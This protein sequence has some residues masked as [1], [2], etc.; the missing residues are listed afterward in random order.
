MC[1]HLCLPLAR[2]ALSAC[3]AE[4]TYNK[5]HVSSKSSAVGLGACSGICRVTCQSLQLRFKAKHSLGFTHSTSVENRPSY[6]LPGIGVVFFESTRLIRLMARLSSSVA[7]STGAESSVCSSDSAKGCSNNLTRR[8]LQSLLLCQLII[9]YPF[10]S[11][12]VFVNRFTLICTTSKPRVVIHHAIF[13]KP[14][15]LTSCG[16]KAENLA[17]HFPALTAVD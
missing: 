2:I 14:A 10:C 5:S 12:C 9:H 15:S 17:L 6:Y 4:A 1:S 13:L 16:C 11:R 8:H 7:C 3:R